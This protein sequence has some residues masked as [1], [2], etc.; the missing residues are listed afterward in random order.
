MA[1]EPSISRIDRSSSPL[2][3]DHTL[4]LAIFGTNVSHGCSMTEAEG[5]IGVEWAESVR[6]AKAAE[7]LGIEAMVP[8]ARWRGF[9]GNT[10]FNHRSFETYTWAAGLAAATE[11]IMV[12][13]TSHVPTI[14]PVLAAKQAA[15]ID[16]ISGGRFGL[17]IV[18]GWNETEIAMFGSPQKDH[19]DRYQMAEEWISIIKRLWTEEGTF[20]FHGKHFHVPNAYAEPKPLQAPHPLVM[21]AGVSPAGRR[22]AA[23]HADVNF[24]LMPTLEEGRPVIAETKQLARQAFKRDILVFGMA[25]VVCRETEREARDYFNYY[26]HEKGDWPAVQN[27]LN[28]FMPNSGSAT[29]EQLETMAVNFIAG[30]AALPLIGTPEQVVE[31]M[32][33]MSKAGMDGITLSWVDYDAGLAQFGDQI[34]PLMVQAGLRQG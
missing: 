2:L 12:F 5:T 11:K 17:N 16:H 23:Q 28:V 3:S 25:Y 9:G 1:G 27:L 14:H 7:R 31:G 19:D 20:D 26:V 34:L 24:V 18:A 13:S 6:L 15:T 32:C 21:S 4:K 10:N 30:Y 33:R 29:P 22:F 8:V